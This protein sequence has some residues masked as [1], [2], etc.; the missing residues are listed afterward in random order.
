M[1]SLGLGGLTK[2]SIVL[3]CAVIDRVHKP[4]FSWEKHNACTKKSIVFQNRNT[5]FSYSWSISISP[6]RFNSMVCA[7]TPSFWDRNSWRNGAKVPYWV[8]H[9][10]GLWFFILTVC[11]AI[12]WRN[13]Q[14]LLT[15]L[16][17]HRNTNCWRIWYMYFRIINNYSF[18]RTQ[19]CILT[20]YSY[21]FKTHNHNFCYRKL[22]KDMIYTLV[23]NF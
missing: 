6:Q 11:M 22:Q 8:A 4:C 20:I 19:N 23:L 2:S 18:L 12:R 10:V 13:Y 5:S 14:T 15:S 9:T 7:I 1:W 17:T 3:W 21:L 16:F